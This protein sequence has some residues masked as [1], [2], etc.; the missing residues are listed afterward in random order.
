MTPD[1]DPMEFAR[2]ATE[3][4][5]EPARTRTVEEIVTYVRRQLYADHVG[6]TRIRGGK[7]ETVAATDGLVSWVDVLQAELG[8]GPNWDSSWERQTLMVS[9]LA[10]DGR[11]PQWARKVTALRI[12][13]VLAAELEGDGARRLGS[14]NVYWTH[15]REFT[16]DDVAFVNLFARYATLTLAGSLNEAGLPMALDSRKLIG[17]AQDVLME[18][19]GLDES[20]AFELLIRYS[21]D[22][23]IRLRDVADHLIA[24]RHLPSPAQITNDA[25]KTATSG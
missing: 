19:F 8:E 24:T 17:Q 25:E 16:A 2:L 5:A 3:L 23:H 21:Q 11:W 4:R 9:D 1:F 20:R 13:S 14:L 12:A 15:R 6:I 7:L 22:H 10:T 18:R